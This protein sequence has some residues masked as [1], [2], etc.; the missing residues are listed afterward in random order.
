[1]RFE[2][3]E[4]IDH[5]GNVLSALALTDAD[6]LVEAFQFEGV[7]SVAIQLLHSY[8]EPQHETLLANYL[9]SRLPGIA[10]TTSS[11]LTREWGEYERANTAVL[12]AY[13]G[14]KARQFLEGLE[15]ALTER[16]FQC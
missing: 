2:V 13:V 5:R 1:L 3:R 15:N 9:A 10:V 14:P 8:V 16:G 11:E 6:R 12:N 7:E 4:R